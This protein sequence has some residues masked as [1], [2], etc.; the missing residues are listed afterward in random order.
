MDIERIK[1]LTESKVKA[2]NI[3]KC[4]RTVLKDYEHTKQDVQEDLSE[5]FKPIIE[6]QKET[7]ETIDE[8]QNKMT[9]QLQKNRNKIVPYYEQ[10][11]QL[12]LPGPSGEEPPKIISDMNKEFTPEEFSKA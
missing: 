1:K 12:A 8:N 7:K 5:T 9:E 2:G 11:Q 10:V 6:A 3:T 4:V